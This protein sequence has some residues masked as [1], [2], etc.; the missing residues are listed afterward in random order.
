M[1]LPG[2]TLA[3]NNASTTRASAGSGVVGSPFCGNGS[4]SGSESQ[5]CCR[6]Y[7]ARRPASAPGSRSRL[8]PPSGAGAGTS[9]TKLR[10]ASP[11]P[12]V[13]TTP[14]SASRAGARHAARRSAHRRSHPLPR[15]HPLPPVPKQVPIPWQMGWLAPDHEPSLLL[16]VSHSIPERPSLEIDDVGAGVVELDKLQ[17]VVSWHTR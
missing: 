17:V 1:A 11:H 16:I 9:C 10:G 13:S 12:S 3:G 15:R 8:A 7:P 4:I 14:P 5:R 2:A 6:R